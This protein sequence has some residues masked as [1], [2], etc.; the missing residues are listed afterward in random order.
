M[1]F[2]EYDLF[3]TS[4]FKTRLN[5]QLPKIFWTDDVKI[6][7]LTKRPICHHPR[8]S[9]LPHVDTSPTISSICWPPPGSSFLL[10]YQALSAIWHG[11]SQWYQ[12]SVLSASVSF[13]EVGRSHNVPNHQWWPCTRRFHRRRRAVEVQCVW[14]R[15]AA[16]P[17]VTFTTPNKRVKTAHVHPPTCNLADWLTR[18][19]SPTIYRCFMLAQLLYRWQHQS[20]IFWIPPRIL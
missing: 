19:G 2:E 1:L 7:K 3:K 13:L 4:N 17:Q 10:E 9:S 20:R 11:S 8:N 18:H 16:L 5:F 12:T 15:A 14:W 6:I